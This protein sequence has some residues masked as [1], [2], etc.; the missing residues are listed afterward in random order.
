M[1]LFLHQ[2]ADIHKVYLSSLLLAY[3]LQHQK[4]DL[5]TCPLLSLLMASL[6]ARYFQV[7]QAPSF[8]SLSQ[9]CP[10]ISD[11]I[12]YCYWLM[13]LSDTHTQ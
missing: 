8:F 2:M 10:H 5:L 9:A 4:N 7:G 1:F 3:L 13:S 11:V 6:L 12:V